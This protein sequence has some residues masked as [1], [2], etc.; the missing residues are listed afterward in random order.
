[1][2]SGLS[3]PAIIAELGKDSTY[4]IH[5][6]ELEFDSGTQR[7]TNAVKDITFNGNVFTASGDL[8]SFGNVKETGKMQINSMSFSLSATNQ[9][10]IASALSENFTDRI[11]TLYKGW[12]DTSDHSLIPVTSGGDTLLAVYRGRI[13]S[14]SLNESPN[15]SSTLTWK[16][17]S[18]MVDFDRTAGRRTNSEDQKVYLERIQHPHVTAPNSSVDKGFDFAHVVNRELQWGKK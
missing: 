12:V 5:A 15:G 6:V 2:R 1:M 13:N 4:M 11:I 16:T 7:V 3:N 18:V 14:F 10:A 9:A 8:L 17:N